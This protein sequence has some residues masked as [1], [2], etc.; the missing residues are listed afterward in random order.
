MTVRSKSGIAGQR[1]CPPPNLTISSPGALVAGVTPDNILVHASTPRNHLLTEV[2]SRLHIAERTGQGVDRA[3][4]EM[5]RVG[6]QPPG[7]VSDHDVRVVVRGGIGNASFVRFISELDTSLGSDV[8]VLL[9]LS[10]LRTRPSLTAARLAELIQRSPAEAEET[11][12]RLADE[13]P[14]VLEPTRR[15]ARQRFPSYRLRSRPLAQLGRAVV[16][17]TRGLDEA[18]SKIIEHVR[19]FGHV[20]NASLQ[21]MFDVHVFAARDLLNTLRRRGIVEKLDEARAGKGVRYG[22]GPQFPSKPGSRS[23]PSS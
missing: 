17:G 3:Y 14:G 18:D 10:A 12:R 20:T 11:L 9:A 2:I 21:R 19:E 13:R 1:Y 15:T 6:K 4:R 23:R 7:F 16:Y 8:E 22:P 5:L